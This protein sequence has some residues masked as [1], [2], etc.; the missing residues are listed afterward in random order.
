MSATL[1]QTELL[2]LGLATVGYV[3]AWGLYLAVFWGGGER[4][5]RWASLLTWAAWMLH[6]TAFSVRTYQAGH[7]PIYNGFEFTADFAGGIVLVHLIFERLSRR[8]EIGVCVLPVALA[9]LAYAWTW[10]KAVEPLVPIFK[11]FWLKIHILTAFAAYSAFAVTF[12]AS[13]LYLFR[14]PGNGAQ[15][16]TGNPSN[17]GTLDRVAYQAA[18][19]G[20]C[21]LSVTIISGAIWAEYVWGRFW[22]W[23]PKETWSLIT[24]FIF[25]A[26]LHTRYHRGWRERRAAVL[27]VAGFLLVLVTFV[28]VDYLSP[29]QHAFLLWDTM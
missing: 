21:F 5:S 22:S 27:G 26:Y 3:A 8:R 18:T 28:G 4:L 2:L 14:G 19:V 25:A 10:P 13:C 11:S 16:V 9:L 24:W 12:A 17:P 15:P 20:F 7:L 29:K 6:A 1:Q 23:D